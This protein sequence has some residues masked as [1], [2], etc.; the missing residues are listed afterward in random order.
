M[1]GSTLEV[2]DVGPDGL[3][4]RTGPGKDAFV[5]WDAL[6][7]PLTRR[8]GLGLGYA[9]TIDTAQGMTSERHIAAFP[10]GT[11]GVDTNKAYVSGSRHR[12]RSW[13]VTSKDEELLQIAARRPL[14]V[15]A[16]LTEQDVWSNVARNLSRASL[17]MT[18]TEFFEK[19][20][21]ENEIAVRHIQA[22]KRTLEEIKLAGRPEAA[23][24]Q[25]T[26][27]CYAA[28]AVTKSLTEL[29]NAMAAFKRSVISEIAAQE[30]FADAIHAVGLDL[31]GALPEM[32]G[33][34]HYL[35]LGGAPCGRKQGLYQGY[36]DGWPASFIKNSKT[37][38]ERK[39]K[40][41]ADRIAMTEAESAELARQAKEKLDQRRAQKLANDTE[42]AMKA[43]AMVGQASPA[44]LQHLY[45]RRKSIRPDDCSRTALVASSFRC[46]MPRARSGMF[47]WV[48]SQAVV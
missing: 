9:L 15:R 8:V 28:A 24:K 27:T 3:T 41:E 45:I 48:V 6:R 37:G 17:R 26:Q 42:T 32:D 16:E 19:A 12:V 35:R 18:A 47:N 34:R 40:A 13:L 38:E 46:G 11:T 29:Q 31:E 44:L 33:Q 2:V 20:S 30:Q 23:I 39:W 14:G 36:L 7:D 10:R 25:R 1:N 22:T 5:S 21:K 4:L 43:R